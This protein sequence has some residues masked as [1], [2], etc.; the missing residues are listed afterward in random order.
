MKILKPYAF[1]PN[2]LNAIIKTYE[3]TKARVITPDGETAFFDIVAGVLQGDTLAPYLFAIVLDY[4]LRKAIA[5][6]EEDLGFQLHRR[7]SRRTPAVVVTDL[8]FADDIALVSQQIEGAQEMLV[9]IETEANN[10][11]LHLNTTKTEAMVFNVSQP[12]ILTAKNGSP[13]KIVENFKYLGAWMHS[14]EKD[15]SVRK[16]LAWS[17]CN[18]LR[19]IL[20]SQLSRKIKVRIFVATVESVLLYGAESWTLTTALKKQLDGCYT[21]MLR[22]AVD[23]TWKE[24]LT[25]D[26]LYQDLQRVSDKLAQRRLRLAGH[27]VR[28]EEEVASDLVLWQPIEGR[29]SRGRRRKTFVDTLLEDTGLDNA[30]ELKTRMMDR[31]TWKVHVEAVAGRPDGRHR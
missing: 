4:A 7:R 16:A 2:L 10:V 8:D 25:N 18:K 24:R 17:T 9:R 3:N 1:P 11:G 6:R 31:T 19:M 22:M 29:V 23:V 26:Q 15:F 27:C 30:A 12:I 13:I 20:S 5:G 14:T 21:R 28:H